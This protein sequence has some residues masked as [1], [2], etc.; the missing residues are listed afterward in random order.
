MFKYQD[1][2]TRWVLFDWRVHN[3]GSVFITGNYI[4]LFTKCTSGQGREEEVKA[5]VVLKD[6]LGSDFT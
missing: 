2:T 3:A 4:T 1:D 6:R 5:K